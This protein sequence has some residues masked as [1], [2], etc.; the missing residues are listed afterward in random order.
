[1]TGASTPVK[2][3]EFNS[4]TTSLEAAK[5]FVGE[6]DGVI[7]RITV[8]TGKVV[9]LLSLFPQEGE[10]LMWPGQKFVVTRAA[11]IEDGYTFLDMI[12]TA[13]DMLVF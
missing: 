11:Y 5:E 13:T 3:A 10:V 12:E 8:T 4:C 1:M 2:W 7:F 9:T 6:N